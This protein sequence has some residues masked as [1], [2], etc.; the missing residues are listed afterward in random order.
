MKTVNA[1]CTLT[2][3]M[4]FSMVYHPAIGAT[5]LGHW[6]MDEGSGTT[7]AD[8]SGNGYD[9]TLISGTW[10][11]DRLGQTGKAILLNNQR[12]D[13]PDGITPETVTLAAWINPTR[14]GSTSSP[15]C[16]F[17]REKGSGATGFGWRLALIND[18]ILRMEAVAPY[19]TSP[20]RYVCSSA[21]AIEL[22][23]WYHIAGTYDGTTVRIYIN[24][25]PA[26]SMQYASQTLINTDVTIPSTIGYMSWGLQYFGGTIDDARIYNGVLNDIEIFALAGGSVPEAEIV[27]NNGRMCLGGRIAGISVGGLADTPF[28]LDYTLNDG[29]DWVDLDSGIYTA[30]PV[31]WNVPQGID[32]DVCRVR[33]CSAANGFVYGESNLFSL[34]PCSVSADLTGDCFVDFA[35][36]IQLAAEWLSGENW[37]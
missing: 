3:V 23:K 35:D 9:G 32:S 11:E 2:F 14:F 33:V 1:L 24:G 4:M 10:A 16:I 8:S 5:L 25:Q 31:Y 15:A 17:S 19:S 18:G 13:I 12:I 22:D 34:K 28:T 21:G 26:G 6:A 30:G 20:A 27:V 29:A 36:L 37:E 7:L